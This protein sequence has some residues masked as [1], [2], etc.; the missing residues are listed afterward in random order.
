[1]ESRPGPPASSVI[2]PHPS[3]IIPAS[4]GIGPW[5]VS[6]PMRYRHFALGAIRRR[7]CASVAVA[8]LHTISSAFLASPSSARATTM[9]SLCKTLA[10]L[11]LLPLLA[12]CEQIIGLEDRVRV[13]DA[14]D[15]VTKDTALCKGYC[16]DV[17]ASCKAPDLDAYT[18]EQNC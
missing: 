11:C 14:G 18:S 16:T 4:G 1:M 2:C 9:K 15:A 5:P 10:V 12:T 8:A 17:M 6:Q 3:R 7:L 13:D